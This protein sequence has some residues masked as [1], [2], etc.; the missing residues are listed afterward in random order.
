MGWGGRAWKSRKYRL[1]GS[2]LGGFSPWGVLA[3]GGSLAWGA[4]AESKLCKLWHGV[5]RQRASVQVG[6]RVG[7]GVVANGACTCCLARSNCACFPAPT[8]ALPALQMAVAMSMYCT[9][10]GCS[11]CACTSLQL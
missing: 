1:G 6:V 7:E 9:A 2:R 10:G 4:Q 5:L 8:D 3:L 11:S